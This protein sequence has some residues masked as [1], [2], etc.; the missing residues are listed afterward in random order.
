MFGNLNAKLHYICEFND[1]QIGW[2]QVTVRADTR[3]GAIRIVKGMYGNVNV[4]STNPTYQ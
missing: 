4:T 3:E 1:P 2:Q